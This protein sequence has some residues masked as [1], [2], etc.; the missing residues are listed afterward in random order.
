MMCLIYFKGI[1]LIINKQIQWRQ[2]RRTKEEKLLNNGKSTKDSGCWY[3]VSTKCKSD[4]T[5]N[6][7][8]I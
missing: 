8:N 7:Y 3:F 4:I 6:V 5:I 1:L 2:F